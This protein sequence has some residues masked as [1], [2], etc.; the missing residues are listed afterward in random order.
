MIFMSNVSDKINVMVKCQLDKK[1]VE[2][3]QKE[4]KSYDIGNQFNYAVAIIEIL[5]ID[6]DNEKEINNTIEI[7]VAPKIQYIIPF[8]S[9]KLA[10]KYLEEL[11]TLKRLTMFLSINEDGKVDLKK[12][13]IENNIYNN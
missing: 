1:G 4:L 13:D 2:D 11:S 5:I 7:N 3:F 8:V 10:E 12:N 6:R 9:K